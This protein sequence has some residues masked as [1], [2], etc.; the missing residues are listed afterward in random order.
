MFNPIL[1]RVSDGPISGG[2][3]DH[4]LSFIAV[5]TLMGLAALYYWHNKHYSPLKSLL[6][7]AMDGYIVV[8]VPSLL[9]H[10]VVL[11][12][13]WPEFTLASFQFDFITGGLLCIALR[14]FIL[15]NSGAEVA[16]DLKYLGIY[17][18]A[19][20]PP[21]LFWHYGLNDMLDFLGTVKF[22]GYNEIAPSLWEITWW[23]YNCLMYYL[24]VTRRLS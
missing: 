5:F 11:H 21:I 10:V 7:G 12:Q 17:A 15:Y 1:W 18:I 23:W 2:G 24:I 19:F 8:I 16:K 6:C 14:I 13:G 4:V 3:A 9:Q 20:I 22:A